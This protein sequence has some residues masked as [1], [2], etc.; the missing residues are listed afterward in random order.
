MQSR[1]KWQQLIKSFSNVY[2]RI[3]LKVP[4]RNI[5]ATLQGVVSSRDICPLRV[6]SLQLAP[7]HCPQCDNTSLSTFLYYLCSVPSRNI[8]ATLECVVFKP[9][10][11]STTCRQSTTGTLTL[12]AVRDIC[13][14]RVDSL[15]LAPLHCPQCGN[16]SL[17][18]FLYYLCS[19]P[20]RNIP[21]NLE[22]VVF[23]PRY[24]STTCRQPTTGTL[25][26]PAIRD[27][28]PLRVDSLQLAPLHCPQ[29]DNTSLSTLHYY[30]CSVPSRNIPATLEG[31][32]SS[33]DICPLR[34]DSLQL[35]PLHCPQ[36]DN[37]SLSTFLHYLCSVPSRNIPATLECVWCSSRDICPLRVDSLQLAP[38]HCPQCDNTSLSTFLYYLC[39]VPSRNIPAT[40]ECVV[41]KPRYMSTTCRQSTTGTLTLPAV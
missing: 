35:A 6:D 5:P 37:T 30:L 41:F 33:R 19:V 14:L 31:V 3:F 38:L 2:M 8:P 22:C 7:L 40:L 36:C 11:M 32:C 20:S 28:C 1:P 16:T 34:V 9:R 23:K 25:T 10:Y 29:C 21:A 39:S 13:P 26:L 4:S 15:Q 27:I 24:M 12:P 18:T 17:S